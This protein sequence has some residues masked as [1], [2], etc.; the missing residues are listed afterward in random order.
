MHVIAVLACAALGTNIGL[1]VMDERAFDARAGQQ[2]TGPS[3][4]SSPPIL[5]ASDVADA[6]VQEG[7]ASNPAVGSTSSGGQYVPPSVA[8][9][10]HNKPTTAKPTATVAYFGFPTGGFSQ[11]KI[12][13]SPQQKLNW[14]KS[15]L[16]DKATTKAPT[17]KAPT[18]PPPNLPPKHKYPSYFKHIT[19]PPKGVRGAWMASV[20]ISPHALTPAC[21]THHV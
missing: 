1:P 19:K 11:N 12:F 7:S 10:K 13:S 4:G 15:V 20:P 14:E 6:G 17:T 21:F 5:P 3:A 9:A 18:P 8:F 16:L 2:P